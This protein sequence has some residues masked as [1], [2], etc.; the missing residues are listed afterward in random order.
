MSEPTGP[1]K[2]RFTPP[3]GACDGHFHVFGP[4]H[5]SSGKTTDDL[6]ALHRRL[7]FERGVFV[8]TTK[9]GPENPQLLEVMAK[10]GG[11]YRGVALVDDSFDERELK[12]MHDCGVR[13]VRFTFVPHLGG[14]PDP[15]MVRRVVKRIEPLRWHVTMLIDP[16]DLIR[17]L[18]LVHAIPLPVVIDHMGRVKAGD[19]VAQPGFQALL[20][21][22]RRDNRWVKISGADRI[23]SAG[24]PF[25]D[26]VPY[27]QALIA[28]APDRVFWGTDWP[29]PN[30]TYDIDD[31][32]LVDLLPLYA[33]DALTQR[34]ILVDNP[35]RLYGFAA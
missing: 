5:A 20:A 10:S 9:R 6:F 16:A 2:P 25:Y 27:A 7:G 24:K 19:G 23:T 31:A 30:N 13:G 26:A 14:W 21:L 12:A 33:P 8:L 29:H 4:G 15:D 18:D 17:I 11:R 34:R 22:V 28:A 1:N 3:P 32:E 35:S